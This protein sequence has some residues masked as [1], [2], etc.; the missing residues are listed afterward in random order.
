[1]EYVV[2]SAH[3]PEHSPG[4]RIPTL[5]APKS[6]TAAALLPARAVAVPPACRSA[7]NVAAAWTI[8][9]DEATGTPARFCNRKDSNVLYEG[10]FEYNLKQNEA[11]SARAESTHKGVNYAQKMSHKHNNKHLVAYGNS[12]VAC[13]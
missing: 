13:V 6:T 9:A 11:Q 5:E 4:H 2:H 7:G 3:A 10:G 1:M 8:G 12:H